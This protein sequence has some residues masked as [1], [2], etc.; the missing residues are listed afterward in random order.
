MLKHY[1]PHGVSDDDD[2]VIWK[3]VQ[4]FNH[5]QA[6]K[7]KKEICYTLTLNLFKVST[8]VYKENIFDM[9]KSLKL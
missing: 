4:T 7:P 6:S 8:V 2:V 1:N 3:M 5:C 9:E